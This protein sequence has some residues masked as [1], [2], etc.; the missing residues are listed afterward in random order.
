MEDPRQEEEYRGTQRSQRR[1]PALPAFFACGLLLGG[2]QPIFAPPPR[3]RGFP[4]VARRLPSRPGAAASLAQL[5]RLFPTTRKTTLPGAP[6]MS[7]LWGSG[8]E[9]GAGAPSEVSHREGNHQ[10]QRAEDRGGGDDEDCGIGH[11]VAYN[12]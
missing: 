1:G 8:A 3:P 12:E 2:R 5:R 4:K 6:P 11:R 9:A 7:E 10:R